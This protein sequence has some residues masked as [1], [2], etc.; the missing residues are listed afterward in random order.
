MGLA[1]G[2]ER[3]WLDVQLLGK[4]ASELDVEHFKMFARLR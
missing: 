3:C 1:A 2:G 4:K